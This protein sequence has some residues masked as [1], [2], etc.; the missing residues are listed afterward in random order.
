M[1]QGE[2]VTHAFK[3]QN[4]G[5][6]TLKISRVQASCGCSKAEASAKEIAP[7]EFGQIEVIF[8]TAGYV[9][10]SRQRPFP[11]YSNDPLNPTTELN[12]TGKVKLE[13]EI[14][15]SSVLFGDIPKHTQVTKQFEI[16]QRGEQELLIDKVTTE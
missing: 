11:S 6:D 12:L 10:A 14:N 15:P 9:G 2:E 13:I 3:F 8:K 4:I 7:G 5:E 1:Y 16:I